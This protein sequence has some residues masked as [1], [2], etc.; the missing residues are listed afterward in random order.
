[1]L[2]TFFLVMGA[3]LVGDALHGSVVTNQYSVTSP[4]AVFRAVGG[5]VCI[6][7]GAHFRTP[8]SE[9][10]SMP[11]D[12]SGQTEGGGDAAGNGEFDPE[13]SPL[14]NDDLEH[15]ESDDEN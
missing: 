6:A 4:A 15:L 7:I 14:S 12:G 10:A 11:S 2:S 3:M 9:Y 5:I 1:M 13:L 8:P